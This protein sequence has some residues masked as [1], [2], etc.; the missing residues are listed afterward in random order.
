MGAV[1]QRLDEGDAEKYSRCGK[2]YDFL[3][4]L[5]GIRCD[6]R[7]RHHRDIYY[8]A[9]PRGAY[10]TGLQQK[11]LQYSGGRSD[12][13]DFVSG[14]CDSGRRDEADSS[15]GGNTAVCQLRWQLGFGQPDDDWAFAKLFYTF[16]KLS[17][18]TYSSFL[19]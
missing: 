8:A 16:D 5:R 1:R 13:A 15:D 11:I 14:V 3:G 10:C 19:Q 7:R 17:T 2:R 9:V 12:H 4:N 18:D 6:F